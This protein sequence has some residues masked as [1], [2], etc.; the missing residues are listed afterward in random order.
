MFFNDHTHNPLTKRKAFVKCTAAYIHWVT[1]SLQLRNATTTTTTGRPKGTRFV[2]AGHLKAIIGGTCRKYNFVATKVFHDEHISVATNT[3]LSWQ[4]MFFVITKSMLML[5]TT[6]YFCCNKQVFVATK[7]LS[8]QA[9][10]CRDQKRVLSWQTRVCCDKTFVTTKIYTC[11]SS[12]QWYKAAT[13]PL[14]LQSL[15]QQVPVP[16]PSPSTVEVHQWRCHGHQW[17]AWSLTLWEPYTSSRPYHGSIPSL[18]NVHQLSIFAVNWGCN[19]EHEIS[20][21]SCCC[22]ECW[23]VHVVLYT[24]VRNVCVYACTHKCICASVCFGM[25]ASVWAYFF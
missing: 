1:L 10:F 5:V 11:G 15:Q 13:C 4:N 25:C 20:K 24:N 2:P 19:N 7:A 21:K 6:K 3:C 12:C 16:P 23:V 18:A 8:R 22:F 9:Y 14:I 17:T